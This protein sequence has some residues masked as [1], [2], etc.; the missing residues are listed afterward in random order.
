MSSGAAPGSR[1]MPYVLRFQPGRPGAR[2][3]HSKERVPF[4]R[5]REEKQ[6]I[7]QALAHTDKN[8]GNGAGSEGRPKE[9]ASFPKPNQTLKP[10]GSLDEG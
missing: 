1:K 10:A 4:F 3:N 2:L 9:T 5:M 6:T 8:I 7:K